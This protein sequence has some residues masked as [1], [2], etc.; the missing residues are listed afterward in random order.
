MNEAAKNPGHGHGHSAEGG[1][2][3]AERGGVYSGNPQVMHT[4]MFM[5]VLVFD[6]AP[7]LEPGRAL[8]VLEKGFK[9]RGSRAVLYEDVNAPRGIGVLTWSEQPDH[10]VT[11]TRPVVLSVGGGLVQRPGHAMLGRSYSTGFENDLKFWLLERPV[12]T[13]LDERWPW[14]VWY[15]LRR[16]GEFNRLDGKEQG[17]ILREHGAIGRAYGEQNLAHDI[18]LAMFGLDQND[19]DF[20]IGLIGAELYP[21][22][23][24][25]QAMRKTQQ[26]SQ[27]MEHMGPFFVGHVARRV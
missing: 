15:P 20:L 23:H 27:H 19:N 7:E 2:D 25:V 11:V 13:A 5:Q 26:T 14:H 4:R 21:L 12:Q 22:S 17:A 10:F 16:K 1:V 9:D 24:V 3:I 18:R 6:C 8:D